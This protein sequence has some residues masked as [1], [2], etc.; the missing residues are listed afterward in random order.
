MPF[1]DLSP[2]SQKFLKK[3]FKSGGLFRSGTSQAD[4]DDMDG[5]D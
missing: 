1:A 2:A 4:K 3:H 5:P